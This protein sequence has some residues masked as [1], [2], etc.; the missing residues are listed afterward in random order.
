MPRMQLTERDGI[1]CRRH[2]TREDGAPSLAHVS[3]GAQFSRRLRPRISHPAATGRE[4]HG[5]ALSSD[6]LLLLPHHP[7]TD[8]VIHR[9]RLCEKHVGSCARSV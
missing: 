6:G 7:A 8:H 9:K 5:G 1:E 2:L 4:P 3:A